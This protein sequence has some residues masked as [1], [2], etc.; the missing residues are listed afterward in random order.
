MDH[1]AATLAAE[2]YSNSQIDRG[3][4]PFWKVLGM[5][6]MK[7]RGMNHFMGEKDKRGKGKKCGSGSVSRVLSLRKIRRG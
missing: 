2:R 6:K 7:D 4:N 5:L 1:V 3:S